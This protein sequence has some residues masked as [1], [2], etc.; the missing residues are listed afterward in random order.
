[1][2][3]GNTDLHLPGRCNPN[4]PYHPLTLHRSH[5][6]KLHHRIAGVLE[7][8]TCGC[9]SSTL[10]PAESCCLRRAPSTVISRYLYQRASPFVTSFSLAIRSLELPPF[11]R[12]GP[13]RMKAGVSAIHQVFKRRGAVAPVIAPTQSSPASVQSIGAKLMGYFG[14]PLNVI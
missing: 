9:I 5:S 10:Y 11:Q 2:D 13:A 12:K 1:M 7:R 4:R 3:V 6:Y 8:C 14:A